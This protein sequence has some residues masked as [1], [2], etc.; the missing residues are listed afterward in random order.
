MMKHYLFQTF[1][2]LDDYLIIVVGYIMLIAR[3]YISVNFKR[4]KNKKYKESTKLYERAFL[5]GIDEWIENT[6]LANKTFIF[7]ARLIDVIVF[8][9]RFSYYMLFLISVIKIITL[10]I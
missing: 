6:Y 3:C 9:L 10:F 2:I 5:L 8:N 7:H 1:N 4:A